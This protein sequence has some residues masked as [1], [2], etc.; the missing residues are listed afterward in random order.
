MKW[1]KCSSELSD[2]ISVAMAVVPAQKRMMFGCP[3]YFVNGNMFAGVHQS[4]IILRLCESDRE[5]IS[6][7]FDEARVF[8]P[9]PG[10][11]MKEYIAVPS[12]VYDRPEIFAE[13]IGKAL[14]NASA[15]PNK[16]SG[17]RLKKKEK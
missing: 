13:W 14:T 16:L 6:R 3:A 2:I 17:S 12:A 4:N 9:F 10:R 8:E 11:L 5:L 15:L 1:E 7:Q